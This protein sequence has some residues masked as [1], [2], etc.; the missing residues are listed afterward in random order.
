MVTSATSLASII[1]DDVRVAL[2]ASLCIDAVGGSCEA[3]DDSVVF[4]RVSVRCRF[5]RGLSGVCRT[6]AF[7]VSNAVNYRW[8]G[9]YGE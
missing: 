3:G 8:K 9:C 5:H 7:W 6:C 2:K 4:R 1:S